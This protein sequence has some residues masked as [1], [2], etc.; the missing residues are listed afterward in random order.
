MNTAAI[1]ELAHTQHGLVTR[2]QALDLGSTDQRIKSLVAT[3]A[4]SRLRRGVF[5]VGAAPETWERRVMG[6]VLAGGP[7]VV[8]SHRTAA[9]LAGLVDRSGRIEISSV[10]GRRPRLTGIQSHRASELSSVDRI[11]LQGIAT[12]TV[13]RTIVDLSS[14]QGTATLAR[15]VDHGIRRGM[16]DLGRLDD[17]ANRLARPG[18]VGTLR[19]QSVLADRIGGPGDSELEGRALEY[20]R[21]GGLPEPTLQYRVERPNGRNAFIDLAYPEQRVGIELDGWEFH[22]QRGAFDDDRERRNDLTLLGWDMFHFT[23]TTTARSLVSTIRRALDRS[24]P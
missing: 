19:M 9:R 10:G 12:T 7:S 2:C 23:S 4:W 3:G 21:A 1:V 6:V 17:C 13:E 14:T 5:A 20:L 24:D 11:T 16:L 15:W 8:A 18:R 22:G